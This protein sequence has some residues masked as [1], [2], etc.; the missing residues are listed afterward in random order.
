MAETLI[1]Y[2]E[3]IR[4]GWDK[5]DVSAGAYSKTGSDVTVPY[6]ILNNAG[7]SD[8]AKV[9][10]ALYDADGVLVGVRMDDVSLSDSGNIINGTAEFEDAEDAVSAKIF[11]WNDNNASLAQAEA[12]GF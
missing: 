2:L 11:V 4:P 8:D 1:S 3:E 9:M 12:I 7:I 6:R 10:T 5:A